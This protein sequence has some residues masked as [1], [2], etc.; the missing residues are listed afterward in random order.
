[1]ADRSD[2]TP[3]TAYCY[4]WGGGE[5]RLYYSNIPKLALRVWK[6][7]KNQPGGGSQPSTPSRGVTPTDETHLHKGRRQGIEAVSLVKN[8][9]EK[10][11]FN[12]EIYSDSIY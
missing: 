3:L 8:G 4:R 9:V 2:K 6:K 7:G 11:L 5:S 12:A 1:M 10:G